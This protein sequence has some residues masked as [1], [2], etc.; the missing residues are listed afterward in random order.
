MSSVTS[1]DTEPAGG[2]AGLGA[3]VQGFLQPLKG[4]QEEHE[5]GG[6]HLS[7]S[8]CSELCSVTVVW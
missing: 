3:W 4:Q 5:D 6:T 2:G 8:Q 1:L 7:H